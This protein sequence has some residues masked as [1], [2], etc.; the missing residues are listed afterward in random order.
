MLLADVL[1]LAS[2]KEIKTGLH[3]SPMDEP[4]P[5]LLID[6][7]TLTGTCISALSNRYIGVFS[8][9][10]DELSQTIID[11]GSSSGE[12][13]WYLLCMISI[14]IYKC[15]CDDS[16]RPF[17]MDADFDEDLKSDVADVLQV[18]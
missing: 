2:R 7:A 1:A 9:R 11:A 15:V 17:P 14:S 12:R 18:R 4:S 5:S 8:N 3:S 13:A 10:M 16:F 6:F